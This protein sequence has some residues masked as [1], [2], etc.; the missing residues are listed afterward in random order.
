MGQEDEAG[1]AAQGVRRLHHRRRP[2]RG[3]PPPTPWSCTACPPTAARRSPPRCSTGPAA[4][5]GARRPTACTPCG[6][7]WRGCSARRRREPDDRL[8]L[9]KPQRQHRVVRL[10]ETHAVVQPGAAGGAP[11]RRGRGGHPDHGVARPRGDRRRQG[12]RPRRVRPCTPCPSCPV[13]QVAPEDHLRRVLGEWVVE[14]AH[15]ANLV[16]LRTPPGSAH[17]VGSALDR[18]GFEGVIGTVAG[19]D[20]VLVVAAEDG[21]G[22]LIARPAGRAG[23]DVTARVARRRDD[24]ERTTRNGTERTERSDG[25]ESGAGLQRRPRHLGGGALAPGGARRRGHR[26]GVDV[27]QGGDFEVVRSGPSRPGRSSRWSIDAR[28]EMAEDFVRARH[29]RQ[30][31]LRGQVPARVGAVAAGDRPPSGGRGPPPRRRRRGPRLHRQGQRPGALRGGHPH[32]GA[33]PRDPGA[34]PDAGA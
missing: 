26:R 18:S 9:G 14:V 23:G 32:A 4:W 3:A 13:H 11:G 5:C 2:R 16:V 1:A 31:P 21:G 12:A 29:R 24:D 20:T 17:V 34:R 19:D 22:A 28:A 33:R 15:S 27:G 6:V 8:K 7:C 25:E 10:L 30:R